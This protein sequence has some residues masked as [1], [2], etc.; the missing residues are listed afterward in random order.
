MVFSVIGGRIGPERDGGILP[1]EVVH[2]EEDD[3]SV[4]FRIRIICHSI[5]FE[6]AGKK[7]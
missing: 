6:L 3:I 4:F 1:A 5:P 7:G 2:Q